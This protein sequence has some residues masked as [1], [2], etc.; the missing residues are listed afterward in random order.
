MV[1]IASG[2]RGVA[3]AVCAGVVCHAVICTSGCIAEAI[4]VGGWTVAIASGY[5][6]VSK[7]I[8]VA[9]ICGLG[10]YVEGDESESESRYDWE[11]DFFHF[12]ELFKL[13]VCP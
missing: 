3:K 9:T 8:G 13:F 6:G 10:R 7:T 11:D 1:T 12:F 5:C 2:G 4:S